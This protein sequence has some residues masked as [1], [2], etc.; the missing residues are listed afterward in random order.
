MFVL[1]NVLQ[2][3]IHKKVGLLLLGS[4]FQHRIVN[5]VNS[6]SHIEVSCYLLV[7]LICFSLALA[8]LP[9]PASR[10]FRAP[11]LTK[12]KLYKIQTFTGFIHTYKYSICRVSKQNST[13]I[14]LY[15]ELGGILCRLKI[16]KMKTFLIW[17]SMYFSTYVN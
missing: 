17:F 14:T 3:W 11:I 2:F 13:L 7:C 4:R 16:G 9:N 10:R 15:L 6:P 8:S 1:Q 5:S 12:K